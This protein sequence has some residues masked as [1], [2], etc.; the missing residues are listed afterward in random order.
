MSR[1]SDKAE[2]VLSANTVSVATTTSGDSNY[3]GDDDDDAELSD[4]MPEPKVFNNS[5]VLS[6]EIEDMTK[7]TD[8]EYNEMKSRGSKSFVLD[9]D[10]CS[11]S[12]PSGCS[13]ANHNSIFYA[14][15]KSTDIKV[16]SHSNVAQLSK[17]ESFAH[18]YDDNIYYGTNSSPN[19]KGLLS[20]GEFDKD[21]FDYENDIDRVKNF[22]Y[23]VKENTIFQ[24]GVDIP[25]ASDY[26]C[27][28]ENSCFGFED[29]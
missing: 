1:R 12:A 7:E 14:D 22:S 21:L 11:S 17:V 24:S 18:K 19:R 27:D 10:L 26:I 16:S 13:Y 4:S 28:D 15:D 20:K 2:P 6:I 9:E 8:T 3:D 25:E 5:T 29:D 23:I